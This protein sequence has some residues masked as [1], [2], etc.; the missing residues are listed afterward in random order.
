M[1]KGMES[2]LV[3]VVGDGISLSVKPKR[4][5]RMWGDGGKHVLEERE[6]SRT[7]IWELQS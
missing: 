2:Q 7:Q 3:T 1:I 6:E 5:N 4:R